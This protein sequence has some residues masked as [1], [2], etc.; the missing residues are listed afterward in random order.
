MICGA[1][2]PLQQLTARAFEPDVAQHGTRGLADKAEELALQGSA[3]SAG[4][5]SEFRQAPIVAEVGTHR[6][7]RAPTPRGSGD[8]A[9]ETS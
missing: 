4:D 7:Q 6:V 3:G 8:V 9:D 5:G 1:G 2:C